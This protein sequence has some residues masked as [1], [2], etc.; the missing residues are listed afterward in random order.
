MSRQLFM[1]TCMKRYV[2][3]LVAIT[4]LFGLGVAAKAETRAEIVVTLPFGFVVGGKKLPASTYTVSRWSGD[5]LVF[6]KLRNS[7]SSAR[8]R[9]HGTF[10]TSRIPFGHHG[11]RHELR[12]QRFCLRKLR[13]QLDRWSHASSQRLRSERPVLDRHSIGVGEPIPATYKTDKGMVV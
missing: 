11:C 8:F 10:I 4:F 12:Q 13:R 9:H 5:N 2:R 1:G 6:G 7:T 3:L